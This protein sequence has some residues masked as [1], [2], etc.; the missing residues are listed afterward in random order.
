VAD[1]AGKSRTGN[2]LTVPMKHILIAVLMLFSACKADN[3]YLLLV[4]D[5]TE[6]SYSYINNKH[7]VIIPPGKYSHSFT[8]TF[9]NYAI[10]AK[11]NK[12]IIGIDRD[13]HVLYNVFIYDN[14]P[15]YFA[16]GYFRIVEGNK[17][18]YA[19]SNGKVAIKP[20]FECAFPFENGRAKVSTNC[21]IVKDDPEH[22]SWVSS[23]WFY[24]DK[25]G[26]RVK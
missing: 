12:G 6:N 13:E 11:S 1:A 10:V 3:G 9:R 20:Q 25:A 19:D 16:D 4:H 23:Q 26:N 17:I 15:D 14:G 22:S 8:D 2:L 21:K 7:Q 18:G 5:T 24:I